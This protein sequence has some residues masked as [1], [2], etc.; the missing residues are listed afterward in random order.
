MSPI[1]EAVGQRRGEDAAWV[2]GVGTSLAT[3]VGSN[4][5]MPVGSPAVG[6]GLS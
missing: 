6:N 4:V 1:H 5:L 3:S 2:A